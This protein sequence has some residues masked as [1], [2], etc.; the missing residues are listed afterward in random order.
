MKGDFCR[1]NL[2]MRISTG[3]GCSINTLLYI[4]WPAIPMN[5]NSELMSSSPELNGFRNL[6]LFYH[7]I[8]LFRKC[9]CLLLLFLFTVWQHINALLKPL[10]MADI[11]TFQSKI[12]ILHMPTCV[13]H[14]N[15]T[16]AES[17]TGFPLGNPASS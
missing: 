11:S 12:D 14:A 4:S 8:R 2:Q 3:P 16:K 15:P 17:S 13:R 10:F 7:Q 1:S 5:T 9:W 6:E